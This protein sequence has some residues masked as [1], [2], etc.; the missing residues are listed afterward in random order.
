MRSGYL[1]WSMEI[2]TRCVI[3]GFGYA[4]SSLMDLMLS[5]LDRYAELMKLKCSERIMEVRESVFENMF[6]ELAQTSSPQIVEDDE[7]A[8]MIVNTS[9]EYREVIA[10]FHHAEEV[11]ISHNAR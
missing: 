1:P 9:E 4:V 10:A 7:Y 11:D 2:E 5:L 8:P 6:H 3:Q